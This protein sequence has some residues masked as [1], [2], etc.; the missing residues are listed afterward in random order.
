MNIRFV[1]FFYSCKDF[2]S[3]LV[4]LDIYY[5]KAEHWK[6][7]LNYNGQYKLDIVIEIKCPVSLRKALKYN[8]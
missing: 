6:T 7:I 3:I 5:T 8:P 2:G 4:F 1:L